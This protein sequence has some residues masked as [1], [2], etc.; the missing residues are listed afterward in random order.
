MITEAMLDALRE[1]VEKEMSP[2]RFFHTAA[3]EKMA[4]YLGELYAPDMIPKLRAA[5]LLHDITKEYSTEQHIAICEKEGVELDADAIFAPKTLHARTAAVLIP[6][7]YPEFADREIIDCV[8]WHT[9]GKADMTLEQK[10]I[11]LADYIDTSRTFDDCVRL[12]EYFMSQ[13]PEQMDA[14]QRLT[15]LTRTLVMSFDMTV[16]GLISD[17]LPISRDTVEA[18]NTL[19]RELMA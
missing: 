2:K 7:L 17:G 4:V 16:V 18:R 9:T 15:H 19:V 14:A 6:H 13:M 10:L 8:R 1:R 11:Y 12:R 3:V 5:A